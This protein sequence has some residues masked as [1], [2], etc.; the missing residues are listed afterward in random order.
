M[1]EL[2]EVETVRRGLMRLVCGATIKSVLVLYPKMVSP[3]VDTFAAILS[4]RT[5]EKIDRRGKYLLVRL[6]DNMTMVS[7]LRME[8]KYNVKPI[9]SPITKHTHVIF[10][11]MDGRELRY[12]DT[13]KFGRMKLM[14]TGTET[15]LPSLANMGPEPTKYTLTFDYMK[16]QFQNSKKAI[17]PFLLD[18]RNIA[19]LGNIYVDETL[20]MS[21]IHPLQEVNKIPDFQIRQL[22]ENIIKEINMAIL[23]NGTT[24]HSFSTLLGE[25]G[26]FQNHLKVYGRK[27]LTCYRCN[28]L[29]E[30]IKVANR[31][32]TFCPYCQKYHKHVNQ[33]MILGLT[34][35][36][37]TGKSTVTTIFRKFGIPVIDADVI[38]HSVLS[39]G[40][41]GVEQVLDIFGDRVFE[42]GEINR[43]ALRKIVFNDA[44]ELKR[45]TDITGPLIRAA[46]KEE[47]SN[48]RRKH[49]KIVILD[50]PTLFEAGYTSQTN[51]IM[52]INTSTNQQLDR[53]MTRDF[54]TKDQANNLIKSQLPLKNKIEK[55]DVVIENSGSVE[56][57]RD[58]VVEW[59]DKM[60]FIKN[61]P[62]N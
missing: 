2:P 37:A 6:S 31:G 56:N 61:I 24:V 4:G 41:N 51:E 27:G 13:R 34:G 57:T 39:P 7:H 14:I 46:I 11:L 38:A 35:G 62:E 32:T 45:L 58:Q 1:P 16:Q 25:S 52:V 23:E 3:E 55:A 26:Q 47:L 59:L 50:A 19:G 18:Q 53:L 12:M 28:M 49:A 21:R 33:T 15:T 29:I 60:V 44:V 40:S 42:K 8:G 30:K 9:G 48:Y 43:R 36:I 5:I 22:R 54:L 20:W 17:K 10:T